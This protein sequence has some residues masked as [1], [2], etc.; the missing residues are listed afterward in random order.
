MGC[1]TIG[2][3]RRRKMTSGNNTMVQDCINLIRGSD[4]ISDNSKNKH[5]QLLKNL[6]HP[7]LCS[8][9]AQLWDH[10]P[11]YHLPPLSSVQLW[12]LSCVTTA[13]SVSDT[14]LVSWAVKVKQSSRAAG[15]V[16]CAAATRTTDWSWVR[17]C[18]LNFWGC[19]TQQRYSLCY[20]KHI[21]S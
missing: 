2:W 20:T 4:I 10:L 8:L 16:F 14:A 9:A 11:L 3:T 12:P 21:N 6:L 13:L 18:L 1:S 7:C 19:S 17:R 5:S 15:G